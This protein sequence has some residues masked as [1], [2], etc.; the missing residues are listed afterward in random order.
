MCVHACMHIL[1]WPTTAIQ[2]G[3]FSSDHFYLKISD[4]NISNFKISNL[5]ISSRLVVYS[6]LLIFYER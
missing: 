4:L 6:T 1:R 2:I 5:N 3:H